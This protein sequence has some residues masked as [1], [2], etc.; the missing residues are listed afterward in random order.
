MKHFTFWK[1]W[2]LISLLITI[3]SELNSQENKLTLND[4]FASPKL[5]GTPPS[6]PVWAPNS[7]HFAFSWN[8]P[9]KSGRALW[10]STRDGK[11]LRVSSDKVTESVRDIIWMDE[12]T[13]ISLRG[14]NLWKTSLSQG[15][16]RRFMSVKAGA[17]NLSLSPNTHQVAYIQQGDLWLADLL[18]KKNRQLTKI[19]IPSLSNLTKGRYSRPEREIGPGIWSGPTYKWS[20]DGKTIAIHVVDRR[21]MRKVPFP[22]YL[23]DETN[24][25]EVR[26]S[27]PGD[28]N[29]IR[30]VG[31]LDVE[32]GTIKYLDLPNPESNPSKSKRKPSGAFVSKAINQSLSNRPTFPRANTRASTRTSSRSELSFGGSSPRM[33]SSGDTFPKVQAS[34]YLLERQI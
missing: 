9:S 1:T 32:T 2:A 34:S 14:K 29:E 25:N 16:D 4:I 12:N 27:Y 19:G 20:P 24:P 28:P 8:E 10:V 5:T 15:S 6:R 21:Q 18:S 7:K 17:G 31:L 13:I 30:K 33:V 26:R 3:S 22:N 11:K 23:A